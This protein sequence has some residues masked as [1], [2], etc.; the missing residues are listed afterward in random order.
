MDI[1]NQL[2]VIQIPFLYNANVILNGKRKK[3]MVCLVGYA[4]IEIDNYGDN[5]IEDIGYIKKT[6]NNSDSTSIYKINDP[7][8]EK[9]TFFAS[10]YRPSSSV[11]SLKTL[12]KRTELFCSSIK[13]R[14]N[15]LSEEELEGK[16]RLSYFY[17]MILSHDIQIQLNKNPIFDTKLKIITDEKQI[18]TIISSD[19]ETKKR[20]IIENVSQNLITINGVPYTNQVGPILNNSQLLFGDAFFKGLYVFKKD[21][22][23]EELKHFNDE[24]TTYTKYINLNYIPYFM[25]K[26]ALDMNGYSATGYEISCKPYHFITE[27]LENYMFNMPLILLTTKKHKEQDIFSLDTDEIKILLNILEA[28]KSAIQSRTSESLDFLVEQ[29][30][31][32]IPVIKNEQLKSDF[33]DAIKNYNYFNQYITKHYNEILLMEPNDV[34]TINENTFKQDKILDNSLKI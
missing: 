23:L 14:K 33:I 3:E 7:K 8:H 29:I 30:K 17:F 32:A 31:N 1:K 15:D 25:S 10:S 20:D 11:K 2:Q 12:Q 28:T 19:Y 27:K 9:K 26:S 6:R 18:K 21:L 16:D 13:N 5:D 34:I 4:D 24:Y 22:T